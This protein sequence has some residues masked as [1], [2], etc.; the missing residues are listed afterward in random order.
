[1]ERNVIAKKTTIVGEIKSDGD[2]R[3][4]GVLEGN[5]S[6]KGKIII[7]SGGVIKGNVDASSADVEGEISGQLKVENTLTVKA[8]ANISGDV[9]VGKLSVEPGAVFNATCVMK[10][11]DKGVKNIK[12]RSS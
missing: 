10:V 7:G 9:I 12:L 11:F 3:I 8:A 6:T 5:L 2:F 1:M 4:D